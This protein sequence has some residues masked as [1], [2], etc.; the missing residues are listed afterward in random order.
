MLDRPLYSM[1]DQNKRLV[2]CKFG[3]DAKVLSMWFKI[4]NQHSESPGALLLLQRIKYFDLSWSKEVPAQTAAAQQDF[5]LPP[6]TE[7]TAIQFVAMMHVDHNSTTFDGHTMIH[8]IW[9]NDV[10]MNRLWHTKQAYTHWIKFDICTSKVENS[11]LSV[12][13]SFYCKVSLSLNLLPGVRVEILERKACW[14]GH[15]LGMGGKQL[16]P[17]FNYATAAW[18]LAPRGE[19]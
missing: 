11:K 9:R 8:G 19:V 4:F 2:N 7:N 5:T 17:H 16:R 6:T 12:A 13:S 14:N 18:G 10:S 15:T 3:G 1:R